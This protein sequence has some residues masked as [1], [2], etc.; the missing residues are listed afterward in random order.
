MK[1]LL[2]AVFVLASA[3]F[4]AK[5][6]QGSILVF[7]KV[8]LNTEKTGDAKSSSLNFAPGVGYQ[9]TKNW[10]AGVELGVQ[11]AKYHSPSFQ[12]GAFGRYTY[13]ISNIFSVYSQLGVGYV[14]QG[15]A[16][17]EVNGSK[18]N[19]STSN[20]GLYASLSGP[21][22]SVNVKNN[23]CFNVGFG[24]IDFTST[25]PKGGGDNTTNFGLNFGSGLSVGIS[26]N[27][28]GKK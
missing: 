11:A 2:L 24:S 27:F 12:A 18:Y 23:F 5:A 8:G 25:K 21:V 1:K 26:K 20:R 15:E 4:S 13:P 28:G 17:D 14:S 10:T 7:G 19:V 9:F 3:A 22:V 16:Y 6:Q